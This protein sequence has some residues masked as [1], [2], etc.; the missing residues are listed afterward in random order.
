MRSRLQSIRSPHAG[1]TLIEL[2][3][4]VALLSILVGIA[5]PL[6]TL[7]VQKSR[8]TDARSAVLDLA[9]REE[10][11]FSLANNYS[12][13]PSDL[14]YAGAFPQLVGSGYY[15]INVT[16][17]DPAFVAAGGI[18]PSFVITA[19]PAGTQVNDT[20][21]QSFSDNQIGQQSS[22]NSAAANST[23]ICWN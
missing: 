5:M 14:G 13:L 21:C 4:T 9:G 22:L 8:R 16:V 2:M 1:F 15:T 17:P 12:Q 19:T 7:Q 23:P 18:G 11:F 6:Y 10:R 20:D 3:V